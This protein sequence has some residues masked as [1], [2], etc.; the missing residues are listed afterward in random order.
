MTIDLDSVCPPVDYLREY[1]LEG[2]F[3]LKRDPPDLVVPDR[4][5]AGDS[6]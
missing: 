2:K 4:T 5:F 3:D 6:A 1:V